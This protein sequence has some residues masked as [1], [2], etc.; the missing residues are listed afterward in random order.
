[1]RRNFYE[2]TKVEAYA[3]DSSAAWLAYGEASYG[4]GSFNEAVAAFERGMSL[5]SVQ[6]VFTL[7]SSYPQALR[8][9]GRQ[10]EADAAAQKLSTSTSSSTVASP[11]DPFALYLAFMREHSGDEVKITD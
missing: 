7:R 1:M 3:Q 4:Y 8:A 5:G 6:G 10:K 2:R 9:L 11:P